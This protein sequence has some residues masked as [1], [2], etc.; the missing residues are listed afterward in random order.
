MGLSPMPA[1]KTLDRDARV[2]AAGISLQEGLEKAY[3]WIYDEIARRGV[4]RAAV[5]A[6]A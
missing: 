4:K 1:F 5:S 6:G 3:A 2:V